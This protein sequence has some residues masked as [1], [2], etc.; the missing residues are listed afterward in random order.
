MF[1]FSDRYYKQSNSFK[2]MDDRSNRRE[3]NEMEIIIHGT[4]KR[5]KRNISDYFDSFINLPNRFTPWLINRWY[6]LHHRHNYAREKYAKWRRVKLKIKCK[7]W[8][9]ELYYG[10]LC[11]AMYQMRKDDFQSH[12]HTHTTPNPNYEWEMSCNTNRETY[13]CPNQISWFDM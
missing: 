3:Q 12:Q 7:K 2:I 4:R 6:C 5:R 8:M 11:M 9:E 10:I 1:G 13:C